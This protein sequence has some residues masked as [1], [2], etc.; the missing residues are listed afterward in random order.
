MNT[1]NGVA[2]FT[3]LKLVNAAAGYTLTATATG[4]PAITSTAFDI[5]P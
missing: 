4:L 5:I 1:I 2:T 3:N